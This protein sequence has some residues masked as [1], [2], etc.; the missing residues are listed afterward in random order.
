MKNQ[1]QLIA[2]VDRFGGSTIRA[3]QDLLNSNFPNL[4]GAVHLLPFYTPIDGADAGFDP[5]DHLAIDPRLGTWKD[6]NEIATEFDVLAD[7]IVNHLSAQSAPGRAF[8]DSNGTSPDAGLL[9]SF[10]T[11]FPGGAT[12]A[13]FS[14]I[15]RQLDSLPFTRFALK[16]GKSRWLWTSFTSSQIDIDVEHPAGQRYLQQILLKLAENR[17]KII[18]LDAVGYAIKKA[19]TRCFMIPETFEF[20]E[21]LTAQARALG[22]EVLVEV[23]SH[24]LEQIAIAKKVDWVYDFAL[25]PL[26][27]HAFAFQHARALKRWIAIRPHNAITVL[28]TH[29]G[30]GVQDMGPSSGLSDDGLVPK[31]ELDAVVDYIHR[32]SKDQSR[33]ASGISASNVDLYQI[34]CTFFDA[35]ARNANHY[36]LA[37]ALQF[38]LPGVPQVYYVG[39]LAGENDMALLAQSGVGRD[40]NRQR[41]DE[42][43]VTAALQKPVV[44][45]LIE[46]I[47]LRNQHPAFSGEFA[48]N[49]SS[50]TRLVLRW[51]HLQ[52]WAELKID[53]ESQSGLL[54][55]SKSTSDSAITEWKW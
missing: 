40:I 9:L 3:L 53:F 18:R 22:L 29:D 26:V 19:G 34:N 12:E 54:S 13:D 50:D 15:S 2:Y 39:L 17:V 47:R 21:S 32:N 38:F 45:Q 16:N 28:D 55:C 49:D 6:L 10:A 48:M 20:I 36:L 24:F 52:D 5:I 27:L 33:A 11:V 23:H 35:L 25:P 31:Q 8:I 42:A 1:V 30:I 51:T 14:A 7:V 46:L 37:R 44:Q 43:Q 4:F 41:F